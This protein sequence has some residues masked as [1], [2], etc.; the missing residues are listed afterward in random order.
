MSTQDSDGIDEAL[1]GVT[2]VALT[3]AARIGEQ[4]ARI[5]EQ[6]ARDAQASS[7]QTAREHA[8]RMAAEREAARASLTVVHRP[9][10]WDTA[11][12]GDIT[13]AYQTAKAWN[14]IDPEAVRAEQRIIQV[15]HQPA[16]RRRPRQCR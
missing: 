8:A 13:N 4:H 11:P 12:P 5:R 1:Q 16:T 6:H 3:A 15:R 7:Q 9:Q 14:Q 10:W 2:H